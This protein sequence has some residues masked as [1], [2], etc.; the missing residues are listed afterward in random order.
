MRNSLEHLSSAAAKVCKKGRG[1][2]RYPE[3]FR[4][5]VVAALENHGIGA[6]K[7]ATGL[8]PYTI[9]Q[10]ARASKPA[11]VDVRTADAQE[12]IPVG[13]L[14]E[15]L[16]PQADYVDLVGTNGVHL[17]F[18]ADAKLKLLLARLLLTGEVAYSDDPGRAL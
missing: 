2:R 10:W 15:M 3:E 14:G 1:G 18:V 7:R 16:A 13:I 5:Q 4:Q 12:L 9:R 17:R 8:A 11:T 6:V